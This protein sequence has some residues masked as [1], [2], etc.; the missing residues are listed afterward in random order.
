[1]VLTLVGLGL[2]DE[3]DVSIRGLEAIR[4]ADVVYLENYTATLNVN[5]SRLERFFEK[6]IVLADRDFVEG[7]ADTMLEAAVDKRV[8]CLVVGDPFWSVAEFKKT[9][10]ATTHA[11]LYLR[12]RQRGVAVKVIHN[13]SIMSAVA[14]CGL[15]L[16]RFGE[17]V[18]IPFF[19]GNW[20][21]VSF[22]DKIKKNR[23]NNMHTL[24][25]LDIKV[26]EQTVENMMKGNNIFEPPRFM[27]VNVAI[28]QLLEAAAMKNDEGAEEI[29]AFG[30]ARVGADNQAIVS[31][32]I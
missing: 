11:D 2:H 12:A 15:Q 31:G 5:T 27:T 23:E 17:T 22:Y 28:K 16:Y 30:L 32:E 18:S 3:R 25:L 7:N 29:L 26:K 1:M 20:K 9:H 24:C 4:E 14:A 10:L 19:D 8:V 13:A 21:P 6:P